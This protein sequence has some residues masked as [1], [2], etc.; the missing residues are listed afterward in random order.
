MIRGQ[1]VENDASAYEFD[2]ADEPTYTADTEYDDL[3]YAEDMGPDILDE[4]AEMLSLDEIVQKNISKHIRDLKTFLSS[5]DFITEKGDQNTNI[6]NVAE[7]RTYN[8]PDTHIEEFF[9]ILDLCRRESRMI[10]F[11][12]RQETAKTLKS[13]IM[14]DFDRYQKSR[15]QQIN[16]RH[17]DSLTRHIGKLL[18][19]F[20]DFSQYAFG[21]KYTFKVFYIRKPGVVLVPSNIPGDKSPALYKDGF[22][23]LIPEIQVSKGLKRHLSQELINRGIIKNVFKDIDHIDDPGKMLDK[24]SASN[25][26][27]FLGNSKPGK[28]AYPL[29]HAYELTVY[30]DEDDIDRRMLDVESLNKGFVK[31]SRD[32][33]PSTINLTY[34]LSLGF[35]SMTFDG[36]P[37]WLRKIQMDYRPALETKI[38]LIVE[39]SSKDIL[40]EDEIDAIDNDVDIIALND[41]RAGHLKKLLGILNLNYATEYEKWFKVICAIAHTSINYKPLAIWFSHR[42]P[43][44]WSPSEIDRV[45]IEATNNRFNRKPVTIRSILFWARESSPQ[46]FREIEKEHYQE[47]LKRYAYENEGRVEHSIAARV[48]HAMCG[49]KFVV[50]VGCNEK[51]GRVGYCWYEFVTPGQ[52]MRK[53]EVFKWRKEIDPDNIHLFISE[54][55]PKV[56]RDTRDIIKDRKDNAQNEA[57]MKYWANVERNFRA[58]TS[59]LCNDQFQ[60]GVIKQAQ[61][62]FRLRGFMDELDSYEDI[63][64]VGNGVLKIGANPKLIKGFHE[65]K[66]SKYTETD[67]IPFDPENPYVK[68]LLAAFRDIFP[69]KDVFEFM[70]YHASTG[71]DFRESACILM[72]L[73]GG[74]QNGKSFFAKMIHNTLGHQYCAA[75]KSGLLTAPFERSE[76]ANSAQ[77]HMMDKRYFYFDEFNKCEVLNT[78]RVKSIVNPGWQ[79][80]RDLH[81]RQSNFKNTCNPIA[82]SNF[83]FIIDTTDH[84]TWRRIYYY[85]NKVKFCKNPNPNNPYEKKVD[86]RFINQYTNDPLYKQAMLSIMVH[87][88]SKLCREYGGDIKNVHV[89]TIERETEEFRNRQDALNRFITQMIVKS[90]NAE[91]IGLPSLA[92]KY[93]EWY[94][95]N[96]KPSSQ[97]IIAAQAE[98]ENSRIAVHL[99]RRLSGIYF[100]VGHRVKSYP[101]EPLEEGESD[102]YTPPVAPP[103]EEPEIVDVVANVVADKVEE[104]IVDQYIVDLT[105]N[106]P[107][108]IQSRDR[109]NI[110]DSEDDQIINGFL[111]AI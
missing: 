29:T 91:A 106:A 24:M 88:Y 42:K 45:W 98:L 48:C 16:E 7:K 73:V 79:T 26:V 82:L 43:E 30:V 47:I 102:L 78:G 107:T 69:E 65:Y 100:L 55:M 9:T 95:R 66:I 62:K 41:A 23:I 4:Q 86:D 85:R 59:K 109:D 105:K 92:S 101:E 53:G 68:T 83:D 110:D 49:D 96:V 10:H 13:G 28:P 80:G 97:T 60:N 51:T 20:I 1:N 38:Q 35:Y 56:Y 34:E 111:Q 54:H 71:L 39:K 25:P 15:D 81:Q 58:Y 46:A 74:G 75:G 37:T 99:E 76:G 5:N 57:E 84:G 19:E 36:K 104:N 32:A 50:D 93:I 3:E 63:I 61:Y 6:I 67:Y 87:Y 90:P 52:A 18:N 17:F 103:I 33:E 8:I 27:H 108:H 89:P 44:S 70:M 21:D 72:L 14:I 94:N 22:H 77:M 64:G 11:S 2:E 12:E 31:F 40:P